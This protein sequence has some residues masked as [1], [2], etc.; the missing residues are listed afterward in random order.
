[1]DLFEKLPAQKVLPV[2]VIDNADDAVPL[3]RALLA[4]GLSYAEVTFRTAAAEESIR[5]IA[6]ELPEVTVGAGTVLTVAQAD[7]AVAAGAKFLVSPGFNPTVVKHA[8]SIGVPI[9]PGCITPTEM[10]AGM[11]LGLNVL[12]FFPAQQAGGPD[13]LKA[14]SGPYRDVKFIPTGGINAQN[15]GDYLALDCVFACG[16]SWMAPQKLVAAGDW[17]AITQLCKEI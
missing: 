6:K 12:K 3:V 13:F 5:R 7:A 15:L 16:G 10:E 2:L 17:E 9:F 8:I 14:C 4:G 11:E 1:M